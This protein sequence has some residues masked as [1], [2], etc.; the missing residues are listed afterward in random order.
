LI[1]ADS[2]VTV[3]HDDVK[4]HLSPKFYEAYDAAVAQM[5]G[6][7][8]A[9]RAGQ[10]T[11]PKG[12]EGVRHAIGRPGNSNP[13]E[14]LKDMDQDG[15]D[16]E[17]LYCEFSA[18]RYLYLIKDGWRE[19]TRA[20]NDTLIDFASA[21]PKRLIA[22]YQIPIHDIDIACAEVKRLAESGAKSLQLPV[23][24]P[25]LGAPDYWERVYDPLWATI[26]EADLP[27]CLHIGLAPIEVFKGEFP[28]HAQGVVQPLA[29]FWTSVQYGNFI[30]S[31]VF[32]RFP[33]L[34]VVFVEPGIG[35][36]PWWM[37]QVDEMALHRNYPFPEIKEAPSFYFHRNLF[38][39]FIYEPFA[40]QNLRHLMLENIMWSTDYPHPACSWPDSRALVEEQFKGVP[41]DERE[42]ILSG[43]AARVWN[44]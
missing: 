36:M 16:V 19:A 29:A 34:K 37:F 20:F 21:D 12:F 15:V 24:P 11:M 13:I 10:N 35:W 17:V 6:G 43:N 5:G 32:E 14:R 30:L 4:K 26:Q 3:T 23:H 22:S 39:T 7:G 42:L 33:G 8:T 41:A 27:I 9:I 18:F 44:L 1:S 38:L 40:V 28:N 2:H 31:G 25:E